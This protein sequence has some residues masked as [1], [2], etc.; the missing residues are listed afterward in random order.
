MALLTYFVKNVLLQAASRLVSISEIFKN[1]NFRIDLILIIEICP[2]ISNRRRLHWTLKV[3]LDVESGQKSCCEA[4]IDHIKRKCGSFRIINDWVEHWSASN[5]VRSVQRLV[6]RIYGNLCRIINNPSFAYI[7]S[8]HL[9]CDC[10]AKVAW[11]LFKSWLRNGLWSII[12]HGVGIVCVRSSC[13]L[14]RWHTLIDCHIKSLCMTNCGISY[15]AY[16]ACKTGV[17]TFI[18]V[19]ICC[20][21]ALNTIL[22]SS[23][24]KRG[25]RLR[26]KGWV[27]SHSTR[28]AQRVSVI[29]ISC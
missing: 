14:V 5:R 27:N 21:S 13:L 24:C 29:W 22:G 16:V 6:F 12:K 23:S 18:S 26:C 2:R 4:R 1:T 28:F 20:W 15:E 10:L 17:G 11:C 3:L 7:V 19:R 8:V 9:A 25:P